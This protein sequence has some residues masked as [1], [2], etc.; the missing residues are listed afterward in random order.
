[1]IYLHLVKM[2]GRHERSF[3]RKWY[4][5]RTRGVDT[6]WGVAAVAFL[7]QVV[8]SFGE[9]NAGFLYVGYMEL[10]LIE[11]QQAIWPQTVSFIVGYPAG[12]VVSL[13][14]RWL[15]LTTIALIG[16]LFTCVGPIAASFGTNI[17]WM[18][19]AMGFVHGLGTG[20]FFVIVSMILMM[21]FKRY[22][23]IVTG[24]KNLGGTASSAVFPKLLLFLKDAYGFRNS[25]FL[26]G[27]FSMHL[28]AF[29]IL[30]KTPPWAQT[31][32]VE[33]KCDN[34]SD[35]RTSEVEEGKTERPV[36]K[37][38]D[39]HEEQKSAPSIFRTPSFYVILASGVTGFY[40]QNIFFST[41]VDFTVDKGFVESD[42][43]SLM[44]YFA[45]SE[46]VGRLGLPLLADHG[47]IRR[48]TLM[49]WNF[50][51]MGLSMLLLAQFT[52]FAWVQASC[53][54]FA[55]FFGSAVTI[56]G[57][58]IADY[59]GVPRLSLCFG[60]IGILSVPLFLSNPLVLGFSRDQLGSYDNLYRF[61]SG[62][63]FFIGIL[64]SLLLWSEQRN[65]ATSSTRKNPEDCAVSTTFRGVI[66]NDGNGHS[67][68]E[69]L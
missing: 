40:T 23:G 35:D 17:V 25:L 36:T 55:A 21:Y 26:Y 47:Y 7:S 29:V 14:H 12:L 69:E 60:L 31:Q 53:V 1:M 13:L 19:A 6:C 58:L 48:T 22:R 38:L 24:I 52:A 5:R 9:R 65:D 27:A 18:S 66:A 8:L 49:T 11:R 46:I 10:F 45:V 63:Y 2:N 15:S 3:C 28:G 67:L 34:N 41:I 16:S 50:F 32:T 54:L 57:V 37:N 4:N 62:L 20:I 51:L 33:L 59:L 56:E 42:A 39:S 43:A 61:L 68:I 64:W 44:T 30:L